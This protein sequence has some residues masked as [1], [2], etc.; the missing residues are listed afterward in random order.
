MKLTEVDR[1]SR[2]LTKAQFGCLRNAYTINITRGCEF[3]C[4]YCYARGYPDAPFCGEV[5]LYRNLPQKL[6]E[7]LDNPRRRSVIHRVVFNT[8]SDS[9]QTHPDILEITYRTMMVF[10]ERGIGFSF[11]TKGWIPN[12]FIE[13]FSD[14][15]ELIVSR[16]GLVSTSN[17]YRDLFEPNAATV[18]E[19]LQNIERLQNVGVKTEVRI[20]PIIPFY[21]DDEESITK[22]FKALITIGIKTVSLSYLHL[23]PA[24]LNQLKRELPPTEFNVL[25]SCFENKPWTVVGSSTRSKLIPASLRKKGYNRFKHL[26]KK[27]GIAALICSCK[28]PDLPGQQCSSAFGTE[29][30]RSSLKEKSIQLSLFPC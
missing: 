7:E 22:L 25:Q 23:R 18:S 28:N 6:T 14:F 9:F 8:A 27:F 3:T 11:L 29:E 1:K 10:L 5:Q 20:D 24:I 26:A 13:L 30:I 21:T 19:R 16:I 12:R 2:V 4:V 17:R 15:P